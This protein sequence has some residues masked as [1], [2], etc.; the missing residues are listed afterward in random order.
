MPVS[1][2]VH[3]SHCIAQIISLNPRSILD[4]GCGFGLW[5]FLC[6]EYLDVMNERVQPDQWRIRIDGIELFEPYIQAH[7]RALYSSLRIGDIRDIAPELDAYDLIIAGDVIEHLDKDDA[8]RVLQHLYDKASVA[9]MVNIPIGLGWDHPERHGNPGELHRSVWDAADFAQYAPQS[10]LFDL[11]CGKYG[12]FLC[13]K[14]QNPLA[15]AENLYSAAL[16]C[17]ARGDQNAAVEH[18]RQAAELDPA[19]EA[20]VEMLADLL[21]QQGD[22]PEA[23]RVLDAAAAANPAFHY[24]KLAAAQILIAAC[25][26]SAARARLETLLA[27][28]TTPEPFMRQADELRQQILSKTNSAP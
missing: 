19:Q 26:Y 8:L 18:L 16:A 5:G 4:I 15:R 11:P 17:E 13:L 22:L 2:S 14:A 24:A 3:I 12:A 7:Q 23:V 1:T 27:D 10:A 20:V 25:R 6:R 28:T 21:L 9:L